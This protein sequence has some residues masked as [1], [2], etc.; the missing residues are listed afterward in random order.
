MFLKNILK[1]FISIYLAGVNKYFYFDV[2]YLYFIVVPFCL[3][4]SW[5]IVMIVKEHDRR[6]FN[7]YNH[8]KYY[9][10]IDGPRYAAL[11]VSFNFRKLYV[12]VFL[13]D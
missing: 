13:I 7:N 2:Y 11:I 6:C 1:H 5:S 8:L 9:W 12:F 10:I 4:L 3:T